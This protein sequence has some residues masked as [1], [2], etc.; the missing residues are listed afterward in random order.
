MVY[1]VVYLVKAYYI[2]PPIVFTS[3]TFKT[4]PPNNI[5]QRKEKLHQRW[6]GPRLQQ[7]PLV[8]LGNNQ[9]FC[10]KHYPSLLVVPYSNFR[11]KGAKDGVD[12]RL[13]ECPH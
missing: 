7:K 3:T 9:N 5:K 12:H 1:M 11:V 2:P 13:L 6:L 10:H 4:L 8:I